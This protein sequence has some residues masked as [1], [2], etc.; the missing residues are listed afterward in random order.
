MK[1]M[2]L[3][4]RSGQSTLEYVI[5]LAVVIG[6]IIGAGVVFKPNLTGTYNTAYSK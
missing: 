1:K 5:I 3:R 4:I 6:V 2:I